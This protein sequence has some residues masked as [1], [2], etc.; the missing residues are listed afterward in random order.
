[1]VAFQ[2]RWSVSKSITS[3]RFAAE[4]LFSPFSSCPGRRGRYCRT[5]STERGLALFVVDILIIYGGSKIA[6]KE[7]DRVYFSRLFQEPGLIVTD[8]RFSVFPYFGVVQDRGAGLVPFGT[9]EFKI[10]IILKG[11]LLY[12]VLGVLL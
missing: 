11:Y 8:Y 5:C 9:V 7:V 1:M 6:L 2:S 3:G 10:N 12:H 4:V